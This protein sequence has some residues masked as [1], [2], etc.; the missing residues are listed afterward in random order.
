MCCNVLGVLNMLLFF[1]EKT[2]GAHGC[3]KLGIEQDDFNGIIAE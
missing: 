1:L 2:E 3:T